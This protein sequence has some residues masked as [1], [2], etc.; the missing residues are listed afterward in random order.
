V[1]AE[2]NSTGSDDVDPATGKAL[3]R[4]IHD[5]LFENEVEEAA[6]G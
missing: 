1:K 3:S 4:R 6:V 2:L 5:M